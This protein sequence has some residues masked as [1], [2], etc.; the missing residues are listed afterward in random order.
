M[1]LQ[2]KF[3][4]DGLV[5]KVFMHVIGNKL[6]CCTALASSRCTDSTRNCGQLHSV[7]TGLRQID[8]HSLV[9]I[10]PTRWQ[11]APM[12]SHRVGPVVGW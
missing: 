2:C 12:S 10:L 6:V 1:L 7:I 4:E 5:G 9:Y 11:L 3:L 8:C